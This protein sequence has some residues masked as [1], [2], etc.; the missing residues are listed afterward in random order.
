MDGRNQRISTLEKFF[1]GKKILVTGHTGFKGAWL[2]RILLGMG[3]D[4]VG[5]SLSPNVSPN[6]YSVLN[7]KARMEENIA[8]IRD[9]PKLAGVCEKERPE[10]V[11]HLAAQPLVRDSY[12]DPLATYSTNVMG[13]ANV[14]ECIRKFKNIQTGVIITTDKVYENRGWVWPYRENDRLGGYDP[15]SSSKAC[16][17]L[18][19]S[20]YVSSFM[21]PQKEDRPAY[22]ASA[23]AGN[24]IGG[25]DWSKDRL[26][27][28]MVRAFFEKDQ[29]IVLRAPTAIRPWQH[30]LD[31]LFGYLTL[32]KKLHERNGDAVGTWNFAPDGDN[33]IDVESLTKRSIRLL[34]KGSFS[35]KKDDTKHEASIL[36]LDA[37]KA[38]TLLGWKPI[39]AMDE[40]LKLTMDWYSA[41]Y[42]GSD[43]ERLTGRQIKEFTERLDYG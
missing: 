9:Y 18:V 23:R 3:S 38:K 34:G 36:K 31:P 24:V 40:C 6:L 25:G 5:Y 43:M 10:I 8:D 4:V 11:F 41:F 15:Y 12:D 35:I 27:P 39:L 13:T 32:A 29:G 22:I 33:F 7:L 30:V 26:V 42:S 19:T 17:E 21:N 14:L 2:C 1:K 28:D 37:T 16:A 20:A